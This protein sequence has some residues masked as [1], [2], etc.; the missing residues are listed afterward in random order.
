MNTEALW[1]LV[2]APQGQVQLGPSL[3]KQCSWH[4]FHMVLW[5]WSCGAHKPADSWVSRSGVGP[6]FYLSNKVLT[7]L[8]SAGLG[9][10]CWSRPAV[11]R[12]NQDARGLP[13]KAALWFFLLWRESRLQSHRVLKVMWLWPTIWP[14]APFGTDNS[15]KA[16]F[17]GQKVL[18]AYCIWQLWWAQGH[19]E[20]GKW[21]QR[22]QLFSPGQSTLE[23]LMML[24]SAW[25]N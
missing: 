25:P 16:L 20:E 17:L 4:S 18:M 11:Q 9:P 15:Q 21:L 3:N 1:R 6:R 8:N 13:L 7:W 24:F 23:M 14:A 5:I 12:L 2:C 19:T 10:Q 22:H